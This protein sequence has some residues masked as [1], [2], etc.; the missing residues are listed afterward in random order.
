MNFKTP[1]SKWD[2]VRRLLWTIV[3][4]IFARPLPKSMGRR[5]KILLLRLFGARVA[6][7]ANV[8]SSAMIFKPWAVGDECRCLSSRRSSKEC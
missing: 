6:W 2:K 4:G 8:Y 1:Y 5:W 7:T 3:W